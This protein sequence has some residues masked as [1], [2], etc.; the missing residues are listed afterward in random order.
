M[1]I[2]LVVIQALGQPDHLADTQMIGQ[3]H[4]DFLAQ[5]MRIAIA[6]EQAFLGGQQGA[7]TV[8]MDRPALEHEPL[9]AVARAALYAEN[10]VGH[11]VV[12][13]PG[14]VQ[15]AVEAAPGVEGPVHTAQTTLTVGH[16]G[17]ACVA[18]PGIIRAHLDY[19]DTR[20]AEL[21]IGILVLR[22]RDAD[23]HRLE[24]GNRLRH[25]GKGR[26]GRLGTLA[27]VIRP[28]RPDHPGLAVGGPFRR[29]AVT[30]GA[31]R[32]VQCIHQDSSDPS[33]VLIGP[34]RFGRRSRKLPQ[35]LR[36]CSS[37]SRSNCCTSTVSSVSLA[38]CTFSPN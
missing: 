14:P 15:P 29:H 37:A 25:F 6:V 11:L 2:G 32:A 38:S 8:H 30:I 4:F 21:Q 27:P 10:L 33:R 9:G 20:V 7:L 12:A 19:P 5:Q 18:H 35:A 1:T 28:L 31:G 16:E 23:S 13:L 3:H 26:L 22:R 34:Y 17:G 24:S 36:M